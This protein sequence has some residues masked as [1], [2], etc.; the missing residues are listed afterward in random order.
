MTEDRDSRERPATNFNRGQDMTHKQINEIIGDFIG[1]ICVIALPFAL[2]F[3]GH[4]LG[5]N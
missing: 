1:A 3:I 5:L 4:G 2:L